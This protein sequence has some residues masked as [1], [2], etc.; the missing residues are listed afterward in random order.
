M[1][2]RRS[3]AAI[4][5]ALPLWLSAC[6]LLSTGKYDPEIEKGIS[7]YQK[8]VTK[9]IKDAEQGGKSRDYDNQEAKTFY[10][11]AA[12]NLSNVVLRAQ[13]VSTQQT[14]APADAARYALDALV[15]NLSDTVAGRRNVD[16]AVQQTVAEISNVLSAPE[17]QGGSCTV[18][19]M[20]ALKANQ[21][22]LESIH[23][24]EKRL[25]PPVTTIALEN[26]DDTVR[27][28]LKAAVAYKP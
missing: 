19:A 13:A 22:I 10:A 5:V 24:R 7:D 26:I 16:P 23:K 28:A 17:L 21:D 20:K 1:L 18:V 25:V 2:V 15:K 27:V 6:S 8:S 3:V 11:D 12:A 14:C 9:F 4:L